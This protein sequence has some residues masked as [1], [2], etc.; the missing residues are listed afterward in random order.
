MIKFIFNNIEGKI[1][2]PNGRV[3][4][5]RAMLCINAAYAVMW[6]LSVRLSIRVSVT[7]V[8][9]VKTN[10]HIFKMFSPPGSH[11]ILVFFSTKRQWRQS[12]GNLLN[13]G[14]E[15]RWGRKKSGF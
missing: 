1:Y 8:D 4:Y 9:H 13:G 2:H 3:F 6:C 11:T 15:C 10:K 12:D 14:V 7:F 5:F